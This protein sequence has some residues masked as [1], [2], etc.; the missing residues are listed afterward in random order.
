MMGE[1]GESGP[2][3]GPIH[4]LMPG[5]VVF[6]GD[7]ACPIDY[8]SF[9]FGYYLF[10]IGWL[11]IWNGPADR[12]RAFLES[13]Q[14]VIQLPENHVS[15]IEAFHVAA[16]ILFLA[17]Y[18]QNPGEKSLDGERKF[19]DH[20]CASYLEEKNFLFEKGSWSEEK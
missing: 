7:A 1:L 13:Y 5:T 18:A 9:S 17:L 10:D 12:R 11:F 3:W 20:E 16:R 6:T 4:T 2:V 15:L 8:N 19:V 14:R